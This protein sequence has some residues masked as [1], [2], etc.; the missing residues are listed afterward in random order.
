MTLSGSG[1]KKKFQKSH[2]NTSVITNQPLEGRY[3]HME[4]FQRSGVDY[5]LSMET[6]FNNND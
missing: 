2:R 5:R 1:C 3:M 6:G 4:E